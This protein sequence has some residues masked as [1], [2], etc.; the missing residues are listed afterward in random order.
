MAFRLEFDESV[1]AG[2][3]R[4]ILE[5][6]HYILEQL[7]ST[8]IVRDMGIHEA[9]KGC[10]RVRAALRLVRNE[11][12]ETVFKKENIRFRDAA[13]KL[14][15]AR[16]S[17]VKIEVLNNLIALHVGEIQVGTFDD[18]RNQLVQDYHATL[19]REKSDQT[20]IPVIVETLNESVEQLETLPI[21]TDGFPAIVWGVKRTCRRGQQGR[22][23]SATNPIPENFHEWR[24][25]VKYLWHQI[26][27][28]MDIHP[29][30][31]IMLAEDLHI[32]ADS[33]GDHHDLVVLGREVLENPDAF[34]A[35]SHMMIIKGWIDQQ[36]VDLE[37]QAL[38]LGKIIYDRS[39]DDFCNDLEGYWR[40]WRG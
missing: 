27:I 37:S 19:L 22:E 39:V 26:E 12:G 20:L 40:A 33:L 34:L 8:E 28:L 17:W 32:L 38:K 15:A 29:E 14:A 36:R 25:R 11:I 7:T 13:Q 4:L 2:I 9:R 30:V 35:E 16:D 31:L 21:Q 3:R 1:S 23:R 5:E 18:F 10:K 6:V 24:K